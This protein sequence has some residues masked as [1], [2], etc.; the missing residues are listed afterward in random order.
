MAS[1][2]LPSEIRRAL[3]NLVFSEGQTIQQAASSL[4]ISEKAAQKICRTFT[5]QE[6]I[7]K[8]DGR[9]RKRRKKFGTEFD[10]HVESFF[11]K[12]KLA[13]IEQCRQSLLK[14]HAISA[15]PTTVYNAMKRVCLSIKETTKN[16]R[17]KVWVQTATPTLQ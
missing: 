17:Q 16:T 4:C 14:D 15:S 8:A 1:K 2:Q 9:K 10:R 12:N 6:Q 11:L 13:T 3:I 7:G 5:R